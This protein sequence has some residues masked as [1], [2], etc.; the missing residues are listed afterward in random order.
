MMIKEK[1]KTPSFSLPISDKIRNHGSPFFLNPLESLVLGP[2]AE[3]NAGFPLLTLE[4]PF[5]PILIDITFILPY[6]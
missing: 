3:P 1:P 2:F 4:R 6:P 5:G